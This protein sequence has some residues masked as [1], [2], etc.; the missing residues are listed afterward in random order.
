MYLRK[1]KPS[2]TCLYSAASMF[3][4]SLS[5]AFQSCFSKGSS[6]MSF[7]FLTVAM[8]VSDSFIL[9]RDA[10]GTVYARHGLE[11]MAKSPLHV[12]PVSDQQ[13]HN[14]QQKARARP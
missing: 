12:N 9:Q 6:L 2:T 1:I 14:R 13:C 4:R 5:A 7:A 8:V 11:I 3:L 10:C